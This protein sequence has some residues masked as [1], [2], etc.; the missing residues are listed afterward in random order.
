MKNVLVT[1]SKGFIG[2]NLV[3]ALRNQRKYRVLEFNRESSLSDL[4]AALT[5]ADVIFHLA[6]ANR[7]L[8]PSQ[9][10]VDNVQLTVQLLDILMDLHRKPLIVF[11]SSIQAELDNPY[12]ISKRTAE[13]ELQR[14]AEA[15]QC[16]VVV[17]RLKNVFGKWCRP[18]YNSVVAT[19]CHNIARDLPITITDPERELELVYIDDVVS[20]FLAEIDRTRSEVYSYAEVPVS[21]RI[22]LGKLAEIIRSFREM[23]RSKHMPDFSD[24]L[25]RYLYATYVANLDEST[26]DYDLEIK[27]DQRGQLAEVFKAKHLGQVFVSITHPGIARG[28]HY[29]HT[30]AEKFVVL[31]GDAEIRLRHVVSGEV[32]RY[33]VSGSEFRVVDIPPG[34]T[35]AIENIGHTD[36][37]VLFW[38]SEVFDPARPDTYPLEVENSEA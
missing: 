17:H 13:M 27:A 1:G 30:K 12:G 32:I 21:Y 37:V 9:F 6:G 31:Y 33:R 5:E 18:N 34:Y 10:E 29:H 25:V 8:D 24:Q 38:A 19:F 26:L 20:A 23:R 36:L 2:K 3:F 11:A 4:R 7:P 14:F 22:T 28:N 35:H 15:T 16:H